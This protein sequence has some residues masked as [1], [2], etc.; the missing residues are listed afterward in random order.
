MEL[1]CVP[2]TRPPILA[3]PVRLGL[4]GWGSLPVASDQPDCKGVDMG[5][6]MC[7]ICIGIGNLVETGI[8][9]VERI[10]NIVY[11]PDTS[12]KGAVLINKCSTAQWQ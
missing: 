9:W 8:A 7:I 5:S 4:G 1:E 12:K 6:G 11:Y 2:I 10:L 3:Q